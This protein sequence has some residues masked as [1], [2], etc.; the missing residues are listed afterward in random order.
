MDGTKFDA[1]A[2]S[3]PIGVLRRPLLKGAIV[4]LAAT[5][6]APTIPAAAACITPG[7]TMASACNFDVGC[8]AN[9]ICQYGRGTCASGYKRCGSPCIPRIQTC[10]VCGGGG[11]IKSCN[12]ACVDTSSDERN[13]GA[14]GNVCGLKQ[15]CSSGH[16]CGIGTIWWNG[17]CRPLNQCV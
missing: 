10:L 3:F 17:S 12:G 8:C 7:T 11:P 4:E 15:A 14:C 2:R 1:V 16:C 5:V 6:A 13:C 9:A